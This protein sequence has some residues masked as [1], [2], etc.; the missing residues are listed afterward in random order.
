MHAAAAVNFKLRPSTRGAMLLFVMCGAVRR[1]GRCVPRGGNTR[2]CSHAGLIGGPERKARRG[3]Y[4]NCA[5]TP[6]HIG[7]GGKKIKK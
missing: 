6:C 7:E 2:D 3:D 1:G 4:E 5:C